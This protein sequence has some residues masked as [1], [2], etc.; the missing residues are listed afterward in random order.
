MFPIEMSY[1]DGAGF[2]PAASAM[3]TLRSC[4]TDLPAQKLN[5]A[6]KTIKDYGQS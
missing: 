6:R 4:Q 2:E 3:P 1:V 5:V